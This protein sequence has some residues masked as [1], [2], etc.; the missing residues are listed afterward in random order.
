VEVER[1]IEAFGDSVDLAEEAARNKVPGDHWILATTVLADGGRIT[2]KGFGQTYDEALA[3]ARTKIPCNAKVLSE[4]EVQH[5]RIDRYQVEATDQIRAEI[6]ERDRLPKHATITEVRQV[7]G[8][9]RGF[10]GFGARPPLFEVTLNIPSIV[11][12]AVE[13]QAKVSLRI[14][15]VGQEVAIVP[16]QGRKLEGDHARLERIDC[17]YCIT[18]SAMNEVGLA[19]AT[20]SYH[21]A[22]AFEAASHADDSN[23]TSSVSLVEQHSRMQKALCEC[24]STGYHFPLNGVVTHSRGVIINYDCHACGRARCLPGL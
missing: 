24:G 12:V 10:L 17:G 6:A 3:S 22:A 11:E 13:Q 21:V 20:L 1:D 19:A 23:F 16:V 15:Q 8:G 2:F 5:Q 18:I 14:G 4:S 7:K 9:S